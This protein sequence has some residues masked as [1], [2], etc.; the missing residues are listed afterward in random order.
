MPE[1]YDE[2]KCPNCKRDLEGEI[3]IEIRKK[4]SRGIG[5]IYFDETVDRNWIQCDGCN[6]V[7]CKACCR[8]SESG[9]CNQC[10]TRFEESSVP[11]RT[12]L[13]FFFC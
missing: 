8:N 13:V 5:E 6:Q 2:P 10:L 11:L 1:Y 7:I 4:A 9:Y 3:V 12:L